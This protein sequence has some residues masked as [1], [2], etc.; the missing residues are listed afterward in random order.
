MLARAE[1]TQLIIG[2]VQKLVHVKDTAVRLH[3]VR[4]AVILPSEPPPAQPAEDRAACLAV[5]AVAA[6]V[7]LNG[8]AA[9]RTQLAVIGVP[10]HPIL[11]PGS[12]HLGAAEHGASQ[13]IVSLRVTRRAHAHL[14]L[15]APEDLRPLLASNAVHHWAVGRDAEA[16]F[17]AIG[18]HV[19][20]EGGGGEV[21]DF[22]VA[23]TRQSVEVSPGQGEATALLAAQHG[24]V[25]ALDG[26]AHLRRKTDNSHR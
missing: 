4:V 14:A 5:H 8:A 22:E 7:L 11:Q 24:Q 20:G 1:T 18:Q 19:G 12:L 2:I 25:V 10:L 16:S 15:R 6:P 26:N 13:P 9:A 21:R 17:V 3:Q 23:E